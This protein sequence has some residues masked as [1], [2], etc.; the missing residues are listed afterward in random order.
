MCPHGTHVVVVAAAVLIVIPAVV[1]VVVV[2]VVSCVLKSGKLTMSQS[3]INNFTTFSPVIRLNVHKMWTRGRQGTGRQGG[4]V[5]ETTGR[6]HDAEA[7]RNK[8]NNYK[9]NRIQYARI[10][11]GKK[12]TK[13]CGK[14]GISS[15]HT[16]VEDFMAT[17][18]NTHTVKHIGTHSHTGTLTHTI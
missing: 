8:S 16:H 17:T 4:K 3:A 11:S 2:A 10:A 9:T 14:K 6:G 13:K 15:V 5:A 7:W 12:R 1:V 18:S